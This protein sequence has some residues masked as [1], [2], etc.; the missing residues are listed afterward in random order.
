VITYG[1]TFVAPD[2][3]S[4]TINHFKFSLRIPTG[5]GYESSGITTDVAI[6][7]GEKLVIGK[8]RTGLGTPVDLFL[9]LTVKLH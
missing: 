9:I 6:R 7:E 4:V 1:D 3:K 2:G 8:V 5:G